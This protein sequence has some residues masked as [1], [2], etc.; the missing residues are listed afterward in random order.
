MMIK[1]PVSQPEFNPSFESAVLTSLG[2]LTIE[3]HNLRDDVTD[4]KVAGARHDE[5]TRELWS[6]AHIE[7]HDRKNE[8]MAVD[9]KIDTLGKAV[10][11]GEL[12]LTALEEKSEAS[13]QKLE[14]TAGH[15][16]AV[17]EEKSSTLKGGYIAMLLFAGLVAFVCELLYHVLDLGKFLFRK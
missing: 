13:L 16:I 5:R 15:R 8:I 17:L 4:L 9:T 10:G 3:L 6:Y 11:A 2:S 14:Q 7:N 12:R 1:N